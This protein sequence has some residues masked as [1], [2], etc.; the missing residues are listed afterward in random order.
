MPQARPDRVLR[1]AAEL[2]WMAEE[3]LRLGRSLPAEVRRAHR[4]R[5]GDAKLATASTWRPS[6]RGRP[7][8]LALNEIGL[9]EIETTAAL[10]V[11]PL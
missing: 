2:V 1:F 4:A 9:V 11:R 3:P 10:A 8:S 7:T 5:L 6:R